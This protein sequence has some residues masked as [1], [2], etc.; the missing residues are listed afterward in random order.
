MRCGVQL[1]SGKNAMQVWCTEQVTIDLQGTGRLHSY[2]LM[3]FPP[4]Q[5]Y[6]VRRVFENDKGPNNEL[7][8]LYI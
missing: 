6:L 3:L 1:I 2:W 7:F 5:Y 8:D 4:S